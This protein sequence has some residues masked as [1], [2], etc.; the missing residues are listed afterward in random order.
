MSLFSYDSAILTAYPTIRAGAIHATGLTNGPTPKNLQASFKDEQT[1]AVE[2]IG[3]IA[4]SEIASLAAWRRA[5]SAFGVSP[6]QYRNAAEALLRRLTKRGD[7]PS[8]NLFVDMANL[9]SVRYALPVAVFDQASVSGG[10]SVRF[11]EGTEAFTDLAS[12]EPSPPEEG[13]VIFVDAANLVSARRWCWRQS[14]QSAAGEETTE[15]LIT[16]EGHHEDAQRDVMAATNDLVELLMNYAADA[17]IHSAQLS[18]DR[19][20]FAPAT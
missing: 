12:G 7:I 2:R 10:T 19:A 16:V 14:R 13:E 9:V 18:P 4:L 3:G 20:F 5:F 6:T 1:A 17:A 11:A 15:V 8:I